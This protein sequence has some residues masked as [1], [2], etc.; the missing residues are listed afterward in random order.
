MGPNTSMKTAPSKFLRVRADWLALREEQVIEPD[1]PIIDAHHHLWDRP[2]WR[3]LFDEFL[4]DVQSGHRV[5]ATVYMQCLAMYRKD[6]PSAL[7]PVG[8]TEFAN[9]IAAMAASGQYGSTRVCDGIVGYADLRVADDLARL[10]DA[11]AARGGSRFKGV[12]QISAWDPNP[13]AANP[14]NLASAGMLSDPGFRNGFTALAA[15]GLTF[16]AFVFHTQLAELVDLARAFPSTR[17]ALNHMGTPLGIAGYQHQRADVMRQ[18]TASMKQLAECENVVVKLG[19]MGMRPAGMEFWDHPAPLTSERL[20]EMMRPCVHT[21]IDFFGAS[22]CM[23]ESNFPVDKASYSYRTCWN[24]FKR[25]ASGASPLEKRW[26]FHDTAATFYGLG[27]W[28]LPVKP[29][30]PPGRTSEPV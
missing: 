29:P 21:C 14:E 6:G 15:R 26:L 10:L 19:G 9:G 4:A 7:R 27:V 16:D 18:W 8:E 2:G 20:A 12:R 25:L 17:I 22:R 1:L 13:D 5:V 11:H 3:Y 23:F 28:E 30:W 24:I